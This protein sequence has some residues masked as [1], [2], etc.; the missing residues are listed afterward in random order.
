MRKMTGRQ[1][2]GVIAMLD[3]LGF[4]CPASAF[5]FRTSWR[6]G[7]AGRRIDGCRRITLKQNSGVGFVRIE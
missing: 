5:D 3:Q 4:I 6:E 1:M 7:A 2:G